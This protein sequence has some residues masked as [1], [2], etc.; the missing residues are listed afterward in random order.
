MRLLNIIG[1]IAADDHAAG[2]S[3]DPVSR[4]TWD[5][6]RS[7]RADFLRPPDVQI[8]CAS[9]SG[10]KVRTFN[11]ATGPAGSTRPLISAAR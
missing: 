8:T 10:S 7:N 1:G 6:G 4:R 11:P 9:S 2:W 3:I 5:M